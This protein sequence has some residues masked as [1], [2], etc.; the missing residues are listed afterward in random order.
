M[1]I[2]LIP[3]LIIGIGVLIYIFVTPPPKPKQKAK[4]EN[5]NE[6]KYFCIKDKGYHV[7]VWPNNQGIG[8]FLEFGIAG[9]TYRDR[10]MKYIGEHAGILEADPTNP[11][12][13]NAIKIL[14]PDGYMV[15][16]VPRDMTSVVRSFSTLPCK[17]FFYIGPY[18]DSEGIHYYSD[19]YIS[20]Q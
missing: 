17:C 13:A 3:I 8:N 7:S 4:E 11:Y 5:V 18:T 15:G 2:G 14:A 20:R 6:L 19:C 1:L 12:D 10:I 16:Y 9:L